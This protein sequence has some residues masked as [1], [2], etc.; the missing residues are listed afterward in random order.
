[1]RGC[2]WTGQN[3]STCKDLR[4]W[5]V[6][7]SLV[8][9]SWLFGEWHT[10]SFLV[11]KEKNCIGKDVEQSVDIVFLS[12]AHRQYLRRVVRYFADAGP[13]RAESVQQQSFIKLQGG[14]RVFIQNCRERMKDD[15][16]PTCADAGIMV[17]PDVAYIAF[18]KNG[19]CCWNRRSQRVDG[20]ESDDTG[21]GLFLISACV[22]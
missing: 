12:R 1:M 14:Y 19:A 22:I 5:W 3:R 21:F 9:Q 17:I 10:G 18:K 20:G 16:T 15:A 6:R 11:I 8:L 7:R 13:G 2:S 4:S